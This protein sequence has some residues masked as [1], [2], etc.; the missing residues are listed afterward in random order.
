M[1]PVHPPGQSHNGSPGVLIPVGRSQAGKGRHHIAAIGVFHLLGQILGLR[2]GFDEVQLVPKPLQRRPG[3]ENGALQGILHFPVQ[4]PGNGGHQAVPAENRLFPRI[5]QQKAA[6]TVGVLRLSGA[7]AGLTEKSR[8]LI[9][10]R[11]RNGNCRPE[12]L[13]KGIAVQAAAGLHLRQH[14]PGDVQLLQDFL[15]PAQ[16][17]DVKEHGSGSVGIVRYM[18]FPAGKLPDEPGFH[19]AEAQ[20]SPLCPDSR[21]GHVFQNPAQLGAGKIGVDDQSRFCPEGIRQPSGLQFVAIAAGSAALPDDSTADG[22]AGFLVPD[23]G[24]F[25]LVGDADGGNASRGGSDV[26]HGLPG[27]LQLS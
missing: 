4:T 23:H 18:D 13:G 27:H 14:T 11:P 19:R 10:R 15:V 17:I 6:G 22:L 8:L 26:L 21:A 3:H 16:G 24:G 25:P 12:E 20:L 7:E 9:P 1:I 2:G 5:H